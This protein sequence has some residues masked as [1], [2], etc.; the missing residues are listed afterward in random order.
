MTE[1]SVIDVIQVYTLGEG[2]V[3]RLGKYTNEVLAVDDFGGTINVRVRD[4]YDNEDTLTLDPF[5]QVDL[6]DYVAEEVFI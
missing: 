5:L 1:L 2:D 4:Q 6:L 3:F